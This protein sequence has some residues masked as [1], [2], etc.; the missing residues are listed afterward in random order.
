M[1]ELTMKRKMMLVIVLGVSVTGWI[2][3]YELVNAVSAGL[4]HQATADEIL[5]LTG[6]RIQT[7]SGQSRPTLLTVWVMNSG[8]KTATL[9]TI[10]VR[11]AT[12]SG[13]YVSFQMQGNSIG[14]SATVQVTVNTTSSGFFFIKGDSYDVKALTGNGNQ[15]VFTL[16]YT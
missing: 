1:Y 9:S 3:A 6:Y 7:D 10:Y 8:T 12:T 16:T 13:S 11:D 14:P 15:F 5:Q 2:T 4:L